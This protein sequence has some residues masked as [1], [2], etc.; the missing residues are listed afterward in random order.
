M[1]TTAH[2]SPGAA[3]WKLPLAAEPWQRTLYVALAAPAA[4]IA[5]A[6]GGRL[7]TWSARRFLGQPIRRTRVRGLLSLPL[8]LLTLVIVGY[9][10]SIVVLNVAYP[11]R[12]LL[13]LPGYDRDAWGGPTFAG[14]WAVHAA[15]GLAVLLAMP[16]ILRG[17][18]QLHARLLGRKASADIRH[19]P[20]HARI[21]SAGPATTVTSR[22]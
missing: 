3:W 21:A 22:S 8:A 15:G 11:I 20:D 17:L 12:P 4:I 9:G 19:G 5:L 18:T 14:V 16:W 13:G 10:W 6:D 7:Q 1:M 2:S